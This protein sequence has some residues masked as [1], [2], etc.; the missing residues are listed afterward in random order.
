MNATREYPV[1]WNDDDMSRVQASL[2]RLKQTRPDVAE[3]AA[4][5]SRR[6]SLG[7]ITHHDPTFKPLKKPANDQRSK[8]R[9]ELRCAVMR[10]LGLIEPLPFDQHQ[11]HPKHSSSSK[12]E[13]EK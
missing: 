13:K 8:K 10:R 3:L 12:K 4:E 9:R 11:P 7:L 5:E 6:I 1:G 2:D